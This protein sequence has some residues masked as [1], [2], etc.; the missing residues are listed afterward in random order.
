MPRMMQTA[1]Q[2]ALEQWVH[3]LSDDQL[4]QYLE[5]LDSFSDAEADALIL[6][7]IRRMT[8]LQRT[9]NETRCCNQ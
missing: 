6:E 4:S 7:D 8:I 1:H 2:L 9:L 5:N 3:G